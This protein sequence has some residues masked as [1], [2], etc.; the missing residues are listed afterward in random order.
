MNFPALENKIYLD[1][2]RS[3]LMYDDLL[4]WRKEHE[5]DFLING[6]QFRANHESFLDNVRLQ[7]NNFINSPDSKT[8]LVNNFST[9]LALLLY[10]IKSSSKILIVNE[11]YPSITN[12][13]IYS[14]FEFCSIENTWDLENQILKGIKKFTPDVFIFSIVQYIDGL[15]IDL[16]FIKKIKTKYPD[17]LI[18]ADGTQFFGTKSF[19]FKSSGID[20]VISSGYKWMLG[21]YGNG[22][23]SFNKIIPLH[24][25]KKDL[26]STNLLEI[27]EQGHLDTLSFG[28]LGFSLN[29]ISSYGM[30]KIENQIN[31][32]SSYAKEILTKKNLLSDKIV[33]RKHHS[34]IFNIKGDHNLFVKLKKN[35][36]ICSKRGD[37]LRIS[38]NFYNKKTEIDLLNKIL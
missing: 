3:G 9:G 24:H 35:K 34:S 11:D 14:G 26:N 16:D 33:R 37:G 19:D 2:A 38:F 20:I 30:K 29:Q 36:I 21:G 1:T 17:I 6:S 13:I 7:I 27:F 22:F 8:C 28:S 15:L 31:L 10:H 5:N 4:K 25:F 32:L 23:I 12:K 18:V